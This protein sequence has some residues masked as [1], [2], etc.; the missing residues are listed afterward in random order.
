MS[1]VSLV[2]SGRAAGCRRRAAGPSMKTSSVVS[3][4]TLERRGLQSCDSTTDH[5]TDVNVTDSSVG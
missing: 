1:Q 2:M 5:L 3:L 4:Q